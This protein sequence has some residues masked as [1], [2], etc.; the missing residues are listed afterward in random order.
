M[1]GLFETSTLKGDLKNTYNKTE[2]LDYNVYGVTHKS[3]EAKTNQ[4]V[5]IKI[6][7]KKYLERICGNKNLED[8]LE[9]IRHEIGCLKIMEG[10][11]S[12]HLI[13]STET[14]DFFYL[15]MDLWDLNLEKYLKNSKK[16][17]PIEEIRNLFKKLNIA[18]KRMFDK[19]IIHGNLKLENIL[20]KNENGKN[21]PF[22]SDYGKKAA[23]DDRLTIMQSTTH[24]SAPELLIGDDYDYKVDLWS[25][26]VILYRLYFNEF[27][28]NG[29]TQVSIFNDIKKKKKLK[30]SDNYYFDDLIKKLLVVDS[31]YRISWEKYFNHKFW[32]YDQDNSQKLD[33]NNLYEEVEEDESETDENN[34]WKRESKY[35]S[36]LLK[37]SK[38]KLFN[39]Y[40]CVQDNDLIQNDKSNKNNK[41][42]IIKNNLQDLKKIEIMEEEGNNEISTNNLIF[43]EINKKVLL[44][45]LIKLV[46]YGCNLENLDIIKILNP[47][48]L[49]EL[50]LSHNN[51]NNIEDISFASF[52]KLITLNLSNNN[53]INI[54]PLINVPFRNLKNLYLSNNIISDLEVLS[55]V[56]FRNLDK[57]KI[58]GNKIKDISIFTKVPFI[59]LTFLELKNNKIKDISNTLG[60]ISISNLI[61]L[62]LSHNLIKAIEGLNAIQFQKLITLDIGN[63][64]ICNIDLLSDV[65]FKDLKKLNLYDNKIENVDVFGKVPF[66]GL[67]ELN[68]SYNKI[69][70]VDIINFMIFENLN[71]LDLNGNEI[72]DLKY[73]KQSIKL[74]ELKELLL[75]NNKLKEKEENK[76]ILKNLKNKYKNL[77]LVYN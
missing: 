13:E 46:L 75:K 55:L 26:G 69:K 42:K 53:I 1:G 72:S 66:K 10:E 63:N 24:Y 77:N 76:S 14:N 11:Y 29:D 74:K 15:V 22:L 73:L 17:L 65:Y 7:N 70:N 71:K 31:N 44:D 40:Y 18:F 54:D 47:I 45:N 36:K 38:N 59:N 9:N 51:I 35:R 21:T 57:L 48:N 27:P 23:L 30:K 6:I 67:K 68:L 61:Y 2:I 3:K 5:A 28:F 56:P 12:I 16:G 19:N 60:F 32:K 34:K 49:L 39:I 58:S 50:D 4:M 43:N 33:E 8:C 62:D 52:E 20:L 64:E 37:N 25:I 41:N